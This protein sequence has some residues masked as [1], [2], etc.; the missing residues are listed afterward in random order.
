[1]GTKKILIVDYD[2]SSLASLQGVFSGLGYQ[3][4]T[5]TDGQAGW[6]KYN[7]ECPDLVLMEAMLPK[8]HGF[9][10]C[11][12]ITSER[13]S[14]ATVFIMTGVYKDRVYRTEALR[15]YGA[16][17][18]F[19]KPLK[20]AELLG[21]VEAVLGKP[22]P[23]PEEPLSA[24]EAA[25]PRGREMQPEPAPAA[26]RKREK[27]PSDDAMFTL[28][29]DLD[30]LAR[31]IPKMPKT[32]ARREKPN[33]PKPEAVADELLKSVL[34]EARP[35]KAAAPRPGGGNGNGNGKA[36]IDQFLAS[37][38]AGLELSK[39][40]IKVPKTA[41][42]PPPPVKPAPIPV[43]PPPLKPAPAPTP[44]PPVEVR[45]PKPVRPAPPVAAPPAPA[46]PIDR[47]ERADMKTTLL[48]GDPGSDI[49]PFFTPEK[50]KPAAPAEKPKTAPAPAAAAPAPAP[51]P[52]RP[53]E[54]AA[55]P[56][57]PPVAPPVA[58]PVRP[59]PAPPKPEPV[60][61]EPAAMDITKKE[62][63]RTIGGDIFQDFHET[64]ETPKGFPKL[65]AVGIVVVAL[66]AAGFVLLRPKRHTA[67]P[68]VV[69]ERVQPQTPAQS[70]PNPAEAERKPAEVEHKA[71]DATAAPVVK[72][73]P[74][75][76]KTQAKPK[77]AEPEPI[78]AEAIL[79]NLAAGA[80]A[81]PPG[82][83]GRLG[84][85][86]GKNAPLSNQ[87]QANAPRL[88]TQETAATPKTETEQPTGTAAATVPPA[89]PGASTAVMTP[90]APPVHEGD[91]VE[92][93][94][95][96]EPPKLIKQVD[97][98]YPAAAQRLGVGGTITVNALIDEKGNVV[99]TGILK[100]ILDD[101]G[102]GR[103]A[104]TA[105]R[106][107]KFEPARKNGVPVKVWKSF[108]ISF[109]ADENP[110]DRMK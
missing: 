72:P 86:D 39:E 87:P 69:Q 84:V 58:A 35:P 70:D 106:K 45:E 11:Q 7:K 59:A 47:P 29:A 46:P 34:V 38:L 102:L 75:K 57:A 8:V 2:Q 76:Q 82:G 93:S 22:E 81:P 36:E 10:L 88:K 80:P 65:V 85:S 95:V 21:S 13:N 14:Q 105:V 15:T 78:T 54:K 89:D 71:A 100:G 9:E 48:V 108:V 24:A 61:P 4:V 1:M 98:V 99:D 64:P 62:I 103:A 79:P 66:A 27:A 68:P 92:L 52:V 43:P 5:A 50:P 51:K 94:A 44:H 97:P 107:W 31:E 16:S 77:P 73:A 101:K 12:R 40:K 23:R 19:E 6:D 42:L 28:P 67:P 63:Q 26:A 74:A 91:L 18:Y 32:A 33:E 37:A 60:R 83:P 25:P 109:K 110:A 56:V 20:M 17:E 90:A 49:S 55:K 41:P 3:V 53:A 30:R 96:T 104:E